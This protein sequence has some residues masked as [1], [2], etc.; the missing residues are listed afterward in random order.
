[1]TRRRLVWTLSLIL[2]LI[3]APRSARA[4]EPG[5]IPR[6]GYVFARVSSED[7]HIWEAARQGLRDLGYVEGQNIALEVRWAEGRYERLPALIAE[8]VRLNVDVLVVGTT[9]G[10]LAAKRATRTIPVVMYAV[11]DPV[12]SGLVAS[13][14]RPGGNLTGLSLFNKEVSGKRLELLKETLPGISRVAV[15]TNPGNPIHAVFWTETQAAA[16]VLGLQLQAIE[17]RRPEDFDPAVAAATRDRAE[18]LLVFDDSLTLGYRTRLVALAAARRL[19]TMYGLR[20]FADAGGLLSYGPSNLAMYRRTAT[21]VDKVLKGAKPADLP[22]EQPTTFELVVNLKAA[23][24]LGLRFPPSVLARADQ[25]I[26]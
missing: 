22:V 11:G 15:L 18:A 14:A 10:A 16:R 13:L 6:I 12:G 2:A 21:F 26:E 23:K 7:Q 17:V 5:K 9:P 24:A 1:M 25:I 19:P 20:E 8:L 4:Q 3:A